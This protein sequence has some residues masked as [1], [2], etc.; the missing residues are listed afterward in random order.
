M[1]VKFYE[2]SHVTLYNSDCRGMSELP[3]NSVQCVV[4][5]P[6]YWGLRKYEGDQ[7]LIWGGDE[8]CEHEWAGEGLISDRRGV[9]TIQGKTRTTT[10]HYG[11]DK[12]R[13]W[14]EEHQKH[15][16]DT[17]C[18]KCGAWKGQFGL[19]PTPELYV[20]HTVEILQ[21]IKRVL[22]KDGVCF[23]NLGDSYFA[24]GGAHKPEHANPGLSKSAQRGG[25]PHGGQNHPNLKP[26]I[27]ASSHSG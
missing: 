23:L 13:T 5:S 15:Y 21:E 9:E 24:S 11:N 12:T 26:K 17:F 27:C 4:T 1:S 14:S 19:E 8:N 7:E 10:R 3:D 2:N 16:Q 25:V 22:R 18:Q 20:Q 6:P